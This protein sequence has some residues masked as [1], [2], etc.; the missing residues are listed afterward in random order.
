MTISI[1]V[2]RMPIMLFR[3]GLQDGS[4]GVLAVK[5]LGQQGTSEI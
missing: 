2:C 3:Y 1:E 5:D 4:F